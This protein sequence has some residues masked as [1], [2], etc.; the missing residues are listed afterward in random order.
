MGGASSIAWWFPDPKKAKDDATNLKKLME[1]AKT[2]EVK[3]W[4]KK[5]RDVRLKKGDFHFQIPMKDV[6]F[7]GRVIDNKKFIR[8]IQLK[9]VDMIVSHR[10]QVGRFEDKWS[11]VWRAMFPS[12]E[13]R[14]A[15]IKKRLDDRA[16]TPASTTIAE[17]CLAPYKEA[18]HKVDDAPSCDIF[19]DT[20][21]RIFW[22]HSASEFSP[23]NI[24]FLMQCEKMKRKYTKDKE[25]DSD[26]AETAV[27]TEMKR[28]YDTYIKD[29]SDSAETAVKTEMKRLYDTYIKD[30]SDMELN[31]AFGTRKKFTDS[32]EPFESED[33]SFIKDKLA[34]TPFGSPPFVDPTEEGLWHSLEA[35]L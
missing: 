28:L 32:F 16:E 34:K 23:E 1:F 24:D 21:I 5:Y 33:E 8:K 10:K 14:K 35:E 27:K 18:M 29:G 20:F 7:K 11:A 22:L 9:M 25:T 4:L 19:V 26:S 3:D 31:I 2:T 13:D 15:A 6:T 17:Q 30:G 12:E